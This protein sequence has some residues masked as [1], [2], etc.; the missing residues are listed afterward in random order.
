MTDLLHDLLGHQAW[1]DAVH[2]H[3]LG[4]LPAA[5]ED[6]G[7]RE[8][9]HHMVLVERAFLAFAR[10][11]APL[12]SKLEDF[13]TMAAL[14]EENRLHHEQARQFLAT[15]TP[16]RLQETVEVPWFRDPPCRVTAAEALC[17]SAMHSHYHRAQN[18]TRLRELGGKP[19]V[20]DLIVWHWKGRPEPRWP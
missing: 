16:A 14:R 1:A 5:L 13:P 2:W 11:E 3:V 7:V 12:I 10:G 19:P 17:Q 6:A 4:K 18:A 8:R 20:V 9:L 15:V